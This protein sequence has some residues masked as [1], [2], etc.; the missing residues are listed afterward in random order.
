M[1]ALSLRRMI[2][3]FLAASQP[4]AFV[5]FPVD[6]ITRVTVIGDVVT[7][8]RLCNLLAFLSS[9]RTLT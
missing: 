6:L 1:A 3:D 9:P 7:M 8:S 2:A 5:V 4:G